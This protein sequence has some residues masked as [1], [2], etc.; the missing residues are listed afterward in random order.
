V[1][2]M[3]KYIEALFED[4]IALINEFNS[5]NQE[6][7]TKLL[8]DLME[9]HD[10]PEIGAAIFQEIKSDIATVICNL[11]T[12][13]KTNQNEEILLKKANDLFQKI[14]FNIINDKRY[15]Q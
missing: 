12:Q 4:A 5:V 2:D 7:A 3:I 15:N 11:K 9:V 8:S 13:L 1:A 14:E 6:L 10:I